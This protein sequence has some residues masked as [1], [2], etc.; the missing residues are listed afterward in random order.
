[1]Q[2]LTWMEMAAKIQQRNELMKA[3]GDRLLSELRN[4]GM[5]SC[6]LK[7]QSLS[8]YYADLA[9]LHQSG[10]IDVWVRNRSIVELD[11]HVKGLGYE[12]KTTAAHVSYEDKTGVEIELHA[13]PAFMRYFRTNREL[14]QWFKEFNGSKEVFNLVYL[15]VHM[16][17]HVLFEG[18]GLATVDG[19]LLCSA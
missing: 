2:Y 4:D 12:P 6:I 7:G 15:M 10:D 16:Y 9:A 8:D 3:K 17:H 19:L 13:V 18:L 11:A 14:V 1:M 5:E